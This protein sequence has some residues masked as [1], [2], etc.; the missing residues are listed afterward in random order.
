MSAGLS[1][2]QG[3]ITHSPRG[4]QNFKI[5]TPVSAEV[6]QDFLASSEAEDAAVATTN[7]IS[8]APDN[9]EEEV[10]HLMAQELPYTVFDTDTE[11]AVASMLNAKLEFDETL[12]TENVLHCGAQV[13]R[14]Q[15]E[16]VVQDVVM[17][18]NVKENESED[19][20][21][22]HYFKFSRT[23]V[24][25]AGKASD[26]S[27][28]LPSAQSISQL[29]GAD[30]GSE[31]EESEA[32]DE[33]QSKKDEKTKVHINHN[34][35]T[36]HLTVA[37]KRLDYK[38]STSAV[39]QVTT[40]AGL[41]GTLSP[42]TL[43][44]SYTH[45]DTAI[46][47]EEE[48][49]PETLAPH[50]EVFL[51]SASGHFVC[52]EDVSVVSQT[53]NQDKEE[54]SSAESAEEFKDDLTDPDF[55]PEAV[56]KKSP[57]S[58]IKAIIL[59]SKH[60]TVNLERV[61]AKPYFQKQPN[62]KLLLAPKPS[63]PVNNAS[64]STAASFCTVASPIVINGQGVL[65]IQP[66][67]TRG[68]TIAIRLERPGSQPQVV[69]HHDAAAP[70]PGMP[71]PQVLLVNRQGQILVKDPMSNAY[72][73]LGSD[74][75]TYNKISQIAK[76][77]HSSTTLQCSAAHMKAQSSSPTVT[78]ASPTF[79]ADRKIIVRVVSTKSSEPPTPTV[80]IS[81]P[82][83]VIT[84]IKECTAQAIIDRAMATHRDVQRTKPKILSS[85]KARSPQLGDSVQ[86]PCSHTESPSGVIKEPD[87]TL[88]E[89]PAP[90]RPQVRVKRV[91]SLSERP[92]RKKSKIDFL[93]D[94]SADL[95][96]AN[97]A[98]YLFSLQKEA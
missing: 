52:G 71:S 21:S 61:S 37:L 89:A 38:V 56:A 34:T 88:Q 87:P 81:V 58:Q 7:G 29:D 35:P 16:G 2:R 57:T 50:N 31:S 49:T 60:N 97:E 28:Q 90:V 48:M 73:P 18:E 30:D 66:S 65:P 42:S 54:T 8:L 93:R 70:N 94:P 40:P 74:S 98:R 14:G 69:S 4:R 79:T 84:S 13:E 36:K 26:P 12:L 91:S 86:S 51:D 72:Q 47:E 82:E 53:E 27:G 55:S 17:Q 32:V 3:A 15:A 22:R 62:V 92:S 5:T 76:I 19:E 9:L 85:A 10:A 75:P 96:K 80:A 41:Q 67:G 39:E 46:Q 1:P 83:P 45:D 43:Q 78:N 59:K 6:P 25:D 77:L 68:R 23:V 24:C 95:D 64:I 33:C 63:G 44:P 11:V 20:E